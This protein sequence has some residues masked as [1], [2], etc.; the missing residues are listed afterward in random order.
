MRG[1]RE[2]RRRRC[3]I[4]WG[5]VAAT[6][7]Y[8]TTTVTRLELLCNNACICTATGFFIKRLDRWFIATNWHVLSGR[9]PR[10]GKPLNSNC[11]IPDT[12]RYV[13][14]VLGESTI[15]WQSCDVGL[16][17]AY[18][19]EA[20]WFQHPT[21]AQEVDVAV[22]PVQHGR[23]G[24]AKDIL[25]PGAHDEDMF[26]DLGAEVF[27]PG[28]P[29]GMTAGGGFPIWK[30]ASIASS[31]EFSPGIDRYILVD[32]ATREG[33]SGAPCLALANWHYYRMDRMTGKV[34]RVNRP[35]T[36]RLLGVYSGRLISKQYI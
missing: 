1:G 20:V 32:T 36:W 24:T 33:M 26:L 25:E 9:D 14:S 29:L 3:M 10:D 22:L 28:F 15:S 8:L 11:A 16:G 7:I 35:L 21:L 18:E 27:L 23:V 30:R 2:P 12:C 17:D 31:T 34:E 5:A 6:G 19:N 4:G 13:F